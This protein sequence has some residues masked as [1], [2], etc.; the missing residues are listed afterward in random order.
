MIA[1]STDMSSSLRGSGGPPRSSPALPRVRT[2]KTAATAT[3]KTAATPSTTTTA[4]TTTDLRGAPSGRQPGR[5]FSACGVSL[6][7]AAYCSFSSF[8]FCC[9]SLIRRLPDR[10]T[11]YLPTGHPFVSWVGAFYAVQG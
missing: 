11:V 1:I 4:T 10:G 5:P 7:S 9:F 3:I 2:N 8:V 6:V